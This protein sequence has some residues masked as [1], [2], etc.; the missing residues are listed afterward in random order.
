MKIQTASTVRRSPFFYVGDK[1]KLVPQLKEH[2]PSDI[3]SYM[4]A[5][6]RLLSDY[7]THTEDF[8]NNLH[9][10]ITDYGLSASFLGRTVPDEYKINYV[11]TYYA[12]F[13]KEAYLKLRTDFNHDK[14][15][16]LKLY[17]LLIYGFNRMLV[18][19]SSDENF[20]TKVRE[21]ASEIKNNLNTHSA[22]SGTIRADETLTADNLIGLIAEYACYEILKNKLGKEYVLKPENHTSRNQIDIQL[23]S[24]KQLKCVSPASETV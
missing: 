23:S 6:H 16:L 12:K 2:F 17:L 13:N 11:K 19:I 3:D 15:D 22:S 1:F 24:G 21:K 10:I 5:L 14:S 8:W 9:E 7:S 4:I 18:I 20:L